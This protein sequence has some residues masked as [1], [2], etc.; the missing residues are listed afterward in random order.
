MSIKESLEILNIT[1]IS[2]E[3]EFTLKKKYKE[4]MKKYHPDV[5]GDDTQAKK[6]GIAYENIKG[7]LNNLKVFKKLEQDNQAINVV[8]PISKLLD[9]Y[10]G[11]SITVHDR[12]KQEYSINNKNIRKYNALLII[13]L[14]VQNNG[15]TYTENFIKPWNLADTYEVSINIPVE[16]LT[17]KEEFRINLVNKECNVAFASQS[18]KIKITLAYNVTINVVINKK[19]TSD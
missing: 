15:I 17:N 6:I 18:A 13:D 9:I 2:E 11:D 12:D 5:C 16:K 1:D 14:S 10:S 8:I 3:T 7:I 19:I 4:L